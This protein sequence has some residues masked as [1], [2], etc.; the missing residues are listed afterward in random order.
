MD[1]RQIA[2]KLARVC[3]KPKDGTS[4]LFAFQLFIETLVLPKNCLSYSKEDLEGW[5]LNYMEG[6]GLFN[7]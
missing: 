5:I 4:D 1:N 2:E 7:E 3:F 6:T